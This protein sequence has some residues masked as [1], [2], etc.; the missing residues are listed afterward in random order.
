MKKTTRKIIMVVLLLV[1][2][3]TF[4]FAQQPSWLQ[5]VGDLTG[6]VEKDRLMMDTIT[7]NILPDYFSASVVIEGSGYTDQPHE[8]Y[9]TIS[10]TRQDSSVW[11]ATG[12]YSLDLES[13][14]VIVETIT[15][16][17]FIALRNTV[18]YVTPTI[19]WLPENLSGIYNIVLRLE[20][21]TWML[22]SF[23]EASA[24]LGGS[25]DPSGTVMVLEG[26]NQDFNIMA[27]DGYEVAD[28]LVDGVSEGAISSYIFTNVKKDHTIHAT[29]SLIPVYTISS[30]VVGTG[31]TITPLGDTLVLEGSSQ[32]F[33]I[34]PVAGYGIADVLVDGGSEGAVG[35]RVFNNVNSDHT[36]EASFIENM[37]Y[38]GASEY[39]ESGDTLNKIGYV[40]TRFNGFAT[41]S[42]APGEAIFNQWDLVMEGVGTVYSF[43]FRIEIERV[44]G[45]DQMIV[46]A[47]KIYS[48]GWEIGAPILIGESFEVPLPGVWVT[49]LYIYDI[50]LT[51]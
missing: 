39:I 19:P 45:G 42:C 9:V 13:N 50:D 48:A 10:H 40:S 28:V 2:G 17:M 22:S 33:T 38:L 12:S 46:V 18:P 24:G 25:I 49:R 34:T 29:F 27:D 51:P 3:T 31:G 4:A 8:V 47:D 6:L 20:S 21:I 11:L 1:A 26:G 36:I 5:F 14:D 30:S 32:A 43:W 44:G 37:V 41:N 15:D 35:F 7:F 23:I 16:G